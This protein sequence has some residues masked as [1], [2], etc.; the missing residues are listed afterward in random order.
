MFYK[1]VDK[2]NKQEMI[3]FLANHFRY[4]TM[5]SWNNSTGWANNVKIPKVIPSKYQD[6]VFELMQTDD[7][8]MSIGD[9]LNDFDMM[10]NYQYQAGINGR[11]GGYI[12]MV[13]GGVKEDTIF[14]FENTNNGRDYADGYGWMNIEEAKGRGLYKKTRRRV[15]TQ[16]GL[17]VDTGNPNELQDMEMSELQEITERVQEF[18][19]VCDNV[20]SMAIDMAKNYEVEEEEILVPQTVKTLSLK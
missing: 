8:Y 16:P 3:D 11:S 18:D 9:I 4:F 19:I 1:K 13:H 17:D 6:A 10:Y 15:F 2:R 12:V 5:N 14:T 20:V 7:F